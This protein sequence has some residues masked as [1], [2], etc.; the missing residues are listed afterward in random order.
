MQMAKGD[1]F[2]GGLTKQTLDNVVNVAAGGGAAM[3][4][5]DGL[6]IL[7]ALAQEEHQ[8]LFPGAGQT[9]ISDA[10]QAMAAVDKA[11]EDVKANSTP[12]TIAKLKQAV[13]AVGALWKKGPVDSS[14]Y[15]TP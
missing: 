3:G 14:F 9:G 15:S 2:G 7:A 10:L 5:A 13:D 11:V 1:N 6:A 12:Q 4:A 8:A